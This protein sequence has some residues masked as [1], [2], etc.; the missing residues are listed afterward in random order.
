MNLESVEFYLFAIAS[1]LYIVHIGFYLVGANMYD[2]WQANRHHKRTHDAEHGT[3]PYEPLVTIAIS[4]HNE[5][6]VIARCLKSIRANTYKRVEVLVV[7]DCSHDR[8]RQF[9][10]KYKRENPGF[11]LRVL[12]KLRNVG[13]GSALNH[14]LRRY[15]TGEL[16]MTLDA[17][18]VLDRDCIANAVSYFTNPKI[19]GVAANVKTFD[20][21]TVLGTLQKLE[22]MVGYRSKKVYSLTNCEF[23]IGG[24]ASTY[25]MSVLRKVGYYTIGTMTE[26]IGLSIKIVS[27]GN[28][29]YRV[30]YGSDVVARTE[31]VEKFSALL[32]QRFRW[33][34]GSLQ[35]IFRHRYLIGYTNFRDYTA[36]LTFY[37]MP[38]AIASEFVLLFAPFS[39]AYVLYWSILQGSLKLI[40]GAYLTITLYTLMTIWFDENSSLTER[41]HLSLYAPIAYFIFY[42][43]DIVQ[44][45]AVA[46][47]LRRGHKLLRNE[48]VADH[49]I[50]PPRVGGE[51]AAG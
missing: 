36:T 6:K 29:A 18:S 1:T 39:W 40:I 49:W 37:R 9:T 11:R 47:C 2:V 41:L 10:R 28:R 26:D 7:D 45:V 34:Y 31:S 42:I 27:Q 43:M 24:V 8:T 48:S 51:V 38:V 14:A 13:K 44:L 16:A 3:E 46:K 30:V 25:R 32:R 5:E 23:V 50:S 21:F 4:A 19:V 12:F 33:K 17:D 20:D 35:N 22:Y 15:A